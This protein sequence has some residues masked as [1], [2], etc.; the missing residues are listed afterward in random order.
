MTP[1]SLTPNSDKSVM[2]FSISILC[3]SKGSDEDTVNGNLTE[4]A[5]MLLSP[6]DFIFTVVLKVCQNSVIVL[7]RVYYRLVISI[8][9]QLAILNE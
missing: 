7:R 3:C 4:F 8:I 5:F 2:P 1:T 6:N 9:I